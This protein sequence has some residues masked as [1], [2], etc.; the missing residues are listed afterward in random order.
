MIYITGDCHGDFSRFTED[1]FPEQKKMT[2]KDYI[3]VLG[4]FG[5]WDKSEMMSN[6][7]DWLDSLPFTLLW[8][9][10]NHENFDMLNELE[11]SEWKGGKVHF[12]RPSIIHLMRGEVFEI[13]GISFYCF[14]GASSH[15]VEGGILNPDNPEDEL[16][17]EKYHKEKIPYRVN[18]YTWWKEELPTIEEINYGRKNLAAHGNDVDVILTHCAPTSIQNLF[19]AGMYD[20]NIITDYLDEVMTTVDYKLWFFGHYHQN[21]KFGDKMYLL[22]DHMIRIL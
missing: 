12:I 6:T 19:P 5:Y 10:G 1:C 22:L 3:I 11:V 2:D 14:G 18:H 9:D 20:Q 7:L 21:L 13:D 15:D 8:I 16:L 4:D 17:A